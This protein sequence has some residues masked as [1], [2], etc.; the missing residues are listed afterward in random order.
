MAG[1][2]L[3]R[4]RY[5]C[6]LF[7]SAHVLTSRQRTVV[8]DLRKL[9]TALERIIPQLELFD[10]DKSNLPM[11]RDIFGDIDTEA[12]QEV[13]KQCDG[14]EEEAQRLLSLAQNADTGFINCRDSMD[15][16]ADFIA[17]DT[18]WANA[19]KDG[20][21]DGIALATVCTPNYLLTRLC[22]DCAQ[23]PSGEDGYGTPQ[24]VEED[25]VVAEE[26]SPVDATTP[27]YH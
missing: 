2:T 11:I 7:Y 9:A 14:N 12:L 26:E 4:M 23:S 20:R 27:E 22:S 24:P 8:F 18:H 15:I 1:D 13:I 3:L 5:V 10:S 17:E 16:L 21:Y 25:E 19:I 6:S